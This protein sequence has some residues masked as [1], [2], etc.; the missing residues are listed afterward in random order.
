MIEF[1]FLRSSSVPL[2]GHTADVQDRKHGTSEQVGDSVVGPAGRGGGELRPGRPLW[3][4]EEVTDMKYLGS[5][6]TRPG[7]G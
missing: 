5:K 7:D 1:V 4:G 6:W 3:G 2:K